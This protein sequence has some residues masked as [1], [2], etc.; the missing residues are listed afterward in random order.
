M[1][2]KGKKFLSVLV[3]RKQEDR[4]KGGERVELVAR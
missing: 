4:K 1:G 2:D 3:E